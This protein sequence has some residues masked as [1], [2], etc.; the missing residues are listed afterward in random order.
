MAM[1]VLFP[2]E[3]LDA[4]FDHFDADGS[5]NISHIEL[6]LS[7]RRA[8]F[9]RGFVP[10]EAPLKNKASRKLDAYWERKNR[11]T[12]ES[13]AKMVSDEQT[14]AEEVRQKRIEERRE[15]ML[16]VMRKNRDEARQKALE[17]HEKYWMRRD[18][19][20]KRQEHVNAID[21]QARQSAVRFLPALPAAQRIA[22]QTW[23]KE[24]TRERTADRLEE[25]RDVQKL[26][27][28]WIGG[29]INFWKE[30]SKEQKA[31]EKLKSAGH[32]ARGR[33]PSSKA[34]KGIA[35]PPM[36]QIEE[37]ESKAGSRKELTASH[38][39]R[40]S[41]PRAAGEAD[42]AAVAAVRA[43][44]SSKASSSVQST[45]RQISTPRQGNARQGSKRGA[46]AA[47]QT[48]PPQAARTRP[49][50]PPPPPRPSA[51]PPL[52]LA[53]PTPAP[54]PAPAPPA[55]PKAP[56]APPVAAAAPAAAAPAPAASRQPAGVAAISQQLRTRAAAPSA[57]APAAQESTAT[58]PQ[59]KPQP[60]KAAAPAAALRKQP[61]QKRGQPARVE[62]SS[63]PT[64][65]DS[66]AQ[67]LTFE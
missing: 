55:R 51:V 8:A 22:K 42:S 56:P 48:A 30:P 1:G 28:E 63:Q 37:Y 2:R 27:D 23:A 7:A 33:A 18:R 10:K 44:T 41:T 16:T 25:I 36:P 17:R 3:V 50:P 19:D 39:A 65:T 43:L 26:Q 46:V 38:A 9:K 29:L 57:A 62:L 20:D 31:A 49:A 58:K 60:P 34:F 47:A 45:P 14:A 24:P 15:D 59:L 61:P 5:G 4:L 67:V 12:M 54:P 6:I 11:M 21:S 64:Y 53:V 13:H 66:G 35:P 40:R 52:P 32:A